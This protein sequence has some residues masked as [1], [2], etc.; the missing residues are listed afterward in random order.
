MIKQPIKKIQIGTVVSDKMINTAVVEVEIWKT[1]RLIKKRYQRHQR[2][3]VENPDNQYKI[4][5]KVRIS[6]SKPLSRHKR[7]LIVGLAKKVNGQ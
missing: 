5:D 4:G 6:E 3:M 1:H 7:W 2:F